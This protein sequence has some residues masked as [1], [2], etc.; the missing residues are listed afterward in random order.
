M[1]VTSP[2][3]ET[4]RK[5][6]ALL[7]EYADNL[8]GWHLSQEKDCVK[9]YN[10]TVDTSPVAIV[11]GE[12]V[13]EG[14]TYTPQQVATVATLPG[15]RK[16][17]DEKYDTSEIK[18]MY[19]RYEALFWV[20]LKAPWPV[21][22][23]DMAATSYR[24]ISEDECYIVM[25]SVQ[26]VL[27]PPVSGCVRANLMISGWKIVKTEV[28]VA[29]TYITQVDL[30][31]SIPSSFLKSI[32]QQVPLCAG[33]V[34]KYI[35]EHGYAPTSVECSAEFKSESFEHAKKEY[36][37]SLD[38]VGNCSWLISRKMYPS[39]FK[40]SLTG[41]ASEQTEDASSGDKL[42]VISG[43]QGPVTVKINKA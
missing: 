17:W 1:T 36:A 31:G 43:I 32:Q 22:P 6:M 9:L 13:L 21:S 19:G 10:K 7:K 35:Q 12:T 3:S 27:I 34:V 4:A 2:H 30:A 42:L 16:I 11:R 20:K 28:G 39:G 14:H 25:T 41:T 26:D 29:I 40:V 15:C 23:R 8:D 38:G 33:S 24:E 5:A 18:A 37:A